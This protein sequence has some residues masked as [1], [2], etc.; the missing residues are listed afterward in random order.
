MKSI[1][2]VCAQEKRIFIHDQKDEN[3]DT[4]MQWIGDGVAMYPALDLPTLDESSIYAIFDIPEK[5]RNKYF[6]R[7]DMDMPENVSF[8]DAVPCENI[9]DPVNIDLC[10]A[11]RVLRPMN[12]QRGLAFLDAKYLLPLADTLDAVEIYERLTPGGN[13][14]FAAKAGFMVLA[15]ITPCDIITTMLVDELEGLTRQCRFALESKAALAAQAAGEAV[16]AAADQTSLE[17]AEE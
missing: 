3:G 16:A 5:N 7:H 9:L 13:V 11:G 10:T 4:V 1:A 6:F 12:T 15:L 17:D 2:R 8:A 14:Y